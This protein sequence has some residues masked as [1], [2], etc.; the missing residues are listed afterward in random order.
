MGVAGVVRVDWG[1]IKLGM[2]SILMRTVLS[3]MACHG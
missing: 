2:L 1:M 3:T